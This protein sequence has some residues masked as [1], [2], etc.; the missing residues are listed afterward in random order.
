MDYCDTLATER[1][2]EENGWKIIYYQNPD[3]G[4]KEKVYSHPQ[5]EGVWNIDE[6]V[7]YTKRKVREE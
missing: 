3:G 7:K 1:W 6:A 4:L 2:L 5:L